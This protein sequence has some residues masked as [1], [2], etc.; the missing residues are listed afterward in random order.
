VA[1]AVGCPPSKLEALN[2]NPQPQKKVRKASPSGD[3]MRGLK[4]RVMKNDIMIFFLV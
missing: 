3:S 2:S 4:L 1:Q